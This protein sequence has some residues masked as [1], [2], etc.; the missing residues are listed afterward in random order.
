MKKTIS[1]SE[2]IE[3]FDN[4]N[5]ADNFSNAGRAAL[6][7]YFEELESDCGV[8]IEFD[9]IAIC[10]EFSEYEDLAEFQA[11]YGKDYEDLDDIREAT[12]VIEIPGSDS[13]IIQDF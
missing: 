2:F 12:Q 4:Y 5:R 13:F 11:D 7:D 10:C 3:E 9:V 8:A 1:R 6:F